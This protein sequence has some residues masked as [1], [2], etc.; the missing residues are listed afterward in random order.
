MRQWLTA[1]SG[2]RPKK[3][4]PKRSDRRQRQRIVRYFDCTWSG[5]FGE[6]RARVSNISP[7]GCYVECRFAIPAQND[8]LSDLTVS[9]PTGALVLQG[10]VVETAPGLGFAVRFAELDAPALECLNALV[11]TNTTH[12]I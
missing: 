6:E 10:T 3:A 2:Q 4:Q 1:L 12:S 9:L 5:G 7:T 11:A 8:V